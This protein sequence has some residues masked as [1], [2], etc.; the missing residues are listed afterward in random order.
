MKENETN[1]VLEND[2]TTNNKKAVKRP[3]MKMSDLKEM[4]NEQSVRINELETKV[5]NLE[6]EKAQSENV[7]CADEIIK[8]IME[9]KAEQDY[10]KM[11]EEG[12]RTWKILA[13][14]LFLFV[15]IVISISVKQFGD[16]NNYKYTI[17]DDTYS[18]VDV[19]DPDFS[20]LHTDDYFIAL[21][22]DGN[23]YIAESCEGMVCTWHSDDG[24]EAGL[25]ATKWYSVNM[26]DNFP[27]YGRILS[28]VSQ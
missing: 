11:K 10:N 26:D 2:S 20:V 17:Q 15:I 3:R 25:S 9:E 14:A 21:G 8:E 28:D 27:G 1:E 7:F 6:K 4:L 22:E 23:T 19:I 24:V 16:Y 12:E 18:E 13:I 5:S